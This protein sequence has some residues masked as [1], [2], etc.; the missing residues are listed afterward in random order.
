MSRPRPISNGMTDPRKQMRRWALIIAVL[1][2]ASYA[3]FEAR[4]YIQGPV[5]HVDEPFAG[6]SVEGPDVHIRGYGRNL[7]YLYINGTQAYLNEEGKLDFTYTPPKGFS[8]LT[9]EG[10][11]RFGRATTIHIPFVV[12]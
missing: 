12:K 11:D 1:L 7:S 10:K 9:A 4:R 5:I 8:I 6:G 2:L 3:L